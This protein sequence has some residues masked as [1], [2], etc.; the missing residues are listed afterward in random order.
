MGSSG[1]DPLSSVSMIWLQHLQWTQQRMFQSH[2]PPACCRLFPPT[3]LL[4]WLAELLVDIHSYEPSAT[5]FNWKDMRFLALFL[6]PSAVSVYLMHPQLD[7]PK[8]PLAPQYKTECV[9]IKSGLRWM[10]TIFKDQPAILNL[11]QHAT[12]LFLL[13]LLSYSCFA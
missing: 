1:G 6:A 7:L 11:E 12:R 4:H 5:Y 2:A 10:E 3:D 8:A 13:F 9:S